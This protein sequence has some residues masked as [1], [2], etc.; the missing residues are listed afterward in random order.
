MRE[1]R[2]YQRG[3]KKIWWADFGNIGGI[4]HVRS[5]HQTR[6]IAARRVADEMFEELQKH[7]QL[8]VVRTVLPM[9]HSTGWLAEL[10]RPEV[11]GWFKRMWRSAECRAGVRKVVW[12]LGESDFWK[13]V[14]ESDGKCAITGLPLYFGP[15]VHHPM[16]PSLDRI[17][18]G[19][20]YCIGNC[21]IVLLAVNYAMN[22]W[23]EELFREIAFSYAASAL[24]NG[25][26]GFDLNSIS[27]KR[28]KT[29]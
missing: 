14:R 23:G 3:K 4:R 2:I 12:A 15:A 18:S 27:R 13:L 9:Q 26:P 25:I 6:E 19:V 22:E 11:E 21:R 5:T 1:T 29:A 16:Q 8:N 7:H 24:R 28:K 20:G 17:E 10:Q